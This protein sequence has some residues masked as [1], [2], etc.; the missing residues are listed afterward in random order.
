MIFFRF[1]C[2]K[3]KIYIFTC[4][5]SQSENI[6]VCSGSALNTLV[7]DFVTGRI[8]AVVTVGLV[9]NLTSFG[10]QISVTILT[11]GDFIATPTTGTYYEK[12]FLINIDCMYEVNFQENILPY[13]SSSRELI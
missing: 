2:L 8:V 5:V 9:A 6:V 3:K 12:Y 10:I 13:P 1:C 11:T 4:V 7:V